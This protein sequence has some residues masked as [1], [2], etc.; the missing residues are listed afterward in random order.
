[1]N[2]ILN[3]VIIFYSLKFEICKQNHCNCKKHLY[4]HYQNFILKMLIHLPKRRKVNMRLKVPQLETIFF[5]NEFLKTIF[6]QK[7]SILL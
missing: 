5:S 7:L 1:M 2:R 3:V 4:A 6:Q